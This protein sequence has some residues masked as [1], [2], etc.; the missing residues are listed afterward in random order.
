M[1]TPRKTFRLSLIEQS[2]LLAK[3]IYEEVFDSIYGGFSF[4]DKCREVLPSYRYD[5]LKEMRTRAAQVPSARYTFEDKHCY[6]DSDSDTQI[7][8]E[9]PTKKDEGYMPS[10]KYIF[11]RNDKGKKVV[12]AMYGFGL[13]RDMVKEVE[14]I[15]QSKL[16]GV[17]GGRLK[18]N[19]SLFGKLSLDVYGSSR[20]FG[21]ANHEEVIEI[22]NRYGLKARRVQ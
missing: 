5:V 16:E 13:H 1:E 6:F 3:A 14:R 19:K 17:S 22:L 20:D 12:G 2:K 21:Q 18:A 8:L 7:C 4:T 9:I 11:A 10:I 15:T